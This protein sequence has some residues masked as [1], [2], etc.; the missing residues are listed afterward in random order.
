M[1]SDHRGVA[2]AIRSRWADAGICLRLA[3]EEAN[4]PFL[5]VR[6]EAYEICFDDEAVDDLCAQALLSTIRSAS[7]RRAIAELPG[8]HT[9]R[10]GARRRIKGQGTRQR[11]DDQAARA[12]QAD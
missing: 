7:Y 11:R 5:S 3:S 6:Q 4:L 9:K 1:A 2:Q 8:Y 10:T 12:Q